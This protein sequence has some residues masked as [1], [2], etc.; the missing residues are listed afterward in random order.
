[1]HVGADAVFFA[2]AHGAQVQR[3]LHVAPAA[4]DLQQLLVGQRD[5]LGGERR[6]AGAQQVLAVEVGLGGDGGL[7]DPQQPGLGG[8]Q[9]ALQPALG[10]QLAGELARARRRSGGRCRRSARTDRSI[11]AWRTGLVAERPR[12]GCGRRRSGRA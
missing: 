2:V 12:R 4:L 7:V 9:E 11:S 8:A 3:R 6:V 10:L 1:M 5:V